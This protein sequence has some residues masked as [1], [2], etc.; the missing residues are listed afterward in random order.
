MNDLLL[1][2]LKC[3]P[4][5]RPPIWLHR[6][7]GRFLPQYRTIRA[8]HSF[9]TLVGTPSLAAQITKLPIDL[10]GMDAAIL[11][12]DILVIAE[13]FGF[14]FDFSDGKGIR[15]KEP[16]QEIRQDVHEAV[17]YVS[18]T[19]KLLKKE[20]KAP[21]IGFCG[22]PYTVST[23]MHRTSPK[24]LEKITEATIDYLH[25]QI[26]AGVDAVQIFDSWAGKLTPLDF[27]T[28][29]LPYLKKIVDAIKPTGIP[30]TLF[31]RGFTRYIKELVSLE[32]AALAFDWEKEMHELRREVPAHIAIQGN[33]NP[34]ILQ[35]PLEALQEKT[36]FI[37]ESMKGKRGFIFNLGHGVIPETPVENVRWLVSN[38]KNPLI[39]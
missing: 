12:S 23:Y 31:G 18:E 20:L 5:P 37:L 24:W 1:R 2:A 10:L 26:K 16:E 32:P 29:A 15:L 9:R 39:V 28:L 17:S 4:V 38:F 22:G 19:I 33:L 34:E 27:Q 25:M 7:A 11:F 8:N 3:E 6:Q 13:V 36:Q 14:T 30:I 21:L 35:G